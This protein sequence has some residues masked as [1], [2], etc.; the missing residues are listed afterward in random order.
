MVCS[1]CTTREFEHD[2]VRWLCQEHAPPLPPAPAAA[3]PPPPPMTPPAVAL[4]SALPQAPAA[5]P[6]WN[7]TTL[8]TTPEAAPAPAPAPPPPPLTPPAMALAPAPA[9][10]PTAAPT[11]NTTSPQTPEA[12]TYNTTSAPTHS[13][14]SS[15]QTPEAE[16]AVSAM[17]SN[18][19]V[20]ESRLLAIRRRER[21]KAKKNATMVREK[22]L[23]LHVREEKVNAEAHAVYLLVVEND[24]QCKTLGLALSRAEEGVTKQEAKVLALAAFEKQKWMTE[25]DNITRIFQDMPPSPV[26]SPVMACDTPVRAGPDSTASASTLC[27]LPAPAFP[28]KVLFPAL[29]PAAPVRTAVPWLS[30]PPVPT[31]VAPTCTTTSLQTAPEAAPAPTPPAPL[32][33]PAMALAPA[34]AQAPSVAPTCNPAQA[35]AANAE[36]DDYLVD[37][38]VPVAPAVRARWG[39]RPMPPSNPGGCSKRK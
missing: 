39:K 22:A 19:Q 21:S 32:P 29:D 30:C 28:A 11:C 9:H 38:V 13:T 18:L 15:L 2:N 8:H 12:G 16:A 23:V 17:R 20:E 14:T 36:L 33:L 1:N 25:A 24:L 6:T 4:I 31:P 7:T 37:L 3:A 34:P 27:S 35:P 26:P 5:A 10:A